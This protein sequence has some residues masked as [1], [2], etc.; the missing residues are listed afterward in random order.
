MNKEKLLEAI[1]ATLVKTKVEKLAALGGAQAYS[2]KDL[3]DL[4]FYPRRPI[5]FRAAWVLEYVQVNFPERFLAVRDEFLQRY[6]AQKNPGCRRHYAKIVMHLSTP[7]W[8]QKGVSRAYDWQSV[9]EATFDWLADPKTPV[10]VKVYCMDILF[11]LRGEADWIGD[12]LRA[13]TEFL[14]RDGSAAIQSR[15]HAILKKL[16]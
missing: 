12:E 3:L 4:T 5:A 15:G 11:N 14:L 2:L 1:L 8:A 16:A 9:I 7:D 6:P 13:Q 10:A